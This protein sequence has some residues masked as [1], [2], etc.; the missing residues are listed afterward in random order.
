MTDEFLKAARDEKRG[1]WLVQKA[2]EESEKNGHKLQF[3]HNK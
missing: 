1:N 2:R 3:G